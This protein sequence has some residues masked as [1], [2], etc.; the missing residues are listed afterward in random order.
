MLK[1]QE[2]VLE[3]MKALDLPR[4]HED[5]PGVELLNIE[6]LRDLVREKAREFDRAM[7]DLSRDRIPHLASRE[8]MLLSWSQVI[9]A[10]CD[11]IVVVHNTSNAMGIDL[12]PFFDEVHRTNM[13][14]V[15]GPKRSDGKALKPKDWKPPRILEMLEARLH[16]DPWNGGGEPSSSDVCRW[17]GSHRPEGHRYDCLWYLAHGKR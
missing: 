1:T 5:E 3:M 2:A 13:A 17:C 14:K 12:E 6:L 10:M 9:D 16:D 15:G 11:L 8:T 7:M 4:P